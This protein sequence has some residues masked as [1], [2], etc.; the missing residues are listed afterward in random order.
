MERRR[1]PRHS[2]IL[3]LEYWETEDSSHGGLVANV[4]ETGL[5]IYSVEDMP[6]NKKLNVRVFFSNGYEFDG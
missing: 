1:H 2:I 3:P 5:L 6:L 4:S